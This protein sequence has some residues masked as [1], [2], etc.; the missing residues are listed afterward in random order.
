MQ[1]T[2]SICYDVFCSI[3]KTCEDCVFDEDCQWCSSTQTCLSIGHSTKEDCYNQ[4]LIYGSE[5][6]CKTNDNPLIFVQNSINYFNKTLGL[7]DDE[8]NDF[9]EEE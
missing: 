1:Y 8:I 3:S 6:N 9:D 7:S 2:Y 5:D 4:P